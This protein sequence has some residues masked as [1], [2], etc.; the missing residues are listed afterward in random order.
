MMSF[1]DDNA[2]VT[3]RR[4]LRR[5]IEETDGLDSESL[6]VVIPRHRSI[7]LPVSNARQSRRAGKQTKQ[8]MAARRAAAKLMERDRG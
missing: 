4:D 7:A 5:V 1:D 8:T 2:E 3:A 6:P